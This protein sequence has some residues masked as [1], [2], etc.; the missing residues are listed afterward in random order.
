M[1][2]V[3]QWMSKVAEEPLKDIAVKALG[4]KP[5]YKSSIPGQR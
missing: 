4:G 3:R 1:P 2:E 5:S